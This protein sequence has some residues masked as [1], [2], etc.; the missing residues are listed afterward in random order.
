[1]ITNQVFRHRLDKVKVK[2]HLHK[3]EL[4][5]VGSMHTDGQRQAMAANNCFDFHALTMRGRTDLI[6]TI[7]GP[8]KARIDRALL[9][10]KRICITQCIGQIGQGITH[11]FILTPV[12]QTTVD[13]FAVRIALRLHLPL[14]ARVENPE[15]GFEDIAGSNRLAPG[16]SA[17]FTPPKSA[18]G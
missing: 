9:F 7:L 15:Y 8:G 3:R 6:N 18:S 14:C 1:M 16:R 17:E 10:I 4:M 5:M 13:Y 2:A 12:L 11:Y